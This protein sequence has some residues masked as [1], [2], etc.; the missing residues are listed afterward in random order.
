LVLE[1]KFGFFDIFKFVFFSSVHAFVVSVLDGE[2]IL[3]GFW[4]SSLSFL[5]SPGCSQAF[6]FLFR[7]SVVLLLNFGI[8]ERVAFRIIFSS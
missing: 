4:V 8:V 3:F 1:Q 2:A 6:L 5:F 7:V